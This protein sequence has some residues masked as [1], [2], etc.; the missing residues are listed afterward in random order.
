MKKKEILRLVRILSAVG[1]IICLIWV[2]SAQSL[3]AAGATIAAIITF[4]GTFAIDKKETE[5]IKQKQ[6]G[7]GNSINVQIGSGENN[8][9]RIGDNK[10]ANK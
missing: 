6:S 1:F 7:S 9:I 3:E 4:V 8:K 2:L 5:S 10:N